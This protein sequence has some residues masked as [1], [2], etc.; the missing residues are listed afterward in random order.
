MYKLLIDG[1]LVDPGRSYP[2][3]NPATGEIIDQAPDATMKEAEAAMASSRRAFDETDWS[4]NHAFRAKCLRQFAEGLERHKDEL[5]AMTIAE[6][7]H[8]LANTYGPALDAPLTLVPYYAELAENYEYTIDL[9]VGDSFGTMHHRWI[10]KEPAGVIAAIIAYNYPTQLALAKLAPALA[11]GCTVILKGA[12]QTPLTTLILGEIIANETDIPAGVVNIITSSEAEVSAV[13]CSDPRVDMITFTGSTPV[14]RAIMAAASDT[15]KKC[16]LELGGKSAMI[17][18]DDADLE[19]P[20]M[21][22]AMGG[23]SHAGQGCAI[24]TRILVHRSKEKELTEKIAEQMRA[25]VVGDP[26]QLETGMGPL[27]SDA[28]RE[29]VAGMVDRAIAEGAV[30][31]TGGHKIDGPGYFYEPTLLSNVTNDMEIAQDELFGPVLVI[32]PFD[33]DEEA[34]AIANDSIFGLSGSVWA[35][36]QERG[37]KVARAIRTGTIGVNGGSYYGCE[38]PFGGYK[39]SGIGREMGVAGLEEFLEIK[40]LALPAG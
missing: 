8:T 4:T 19:I 26:T 5:R 18:L 36:T 16:F 38:S 27:I 22:A 7:G 23:T 15:I 34:I 11:A 24:P 33:T 29:K 28:Q 37:L 17:I 10:E 25:V 9:G 13:L 20:A 32:I 14:G 30:A 31:V 40:T 6:V 35:G 2:S 12:P 1:Q 39:Q 21:A 3:E